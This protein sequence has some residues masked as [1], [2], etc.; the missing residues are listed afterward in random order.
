MRAIG[1]FQPRRKHL[2]GLILAPLVMWVLAVELMP[3]EETEE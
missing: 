3:E 2:L 1:R